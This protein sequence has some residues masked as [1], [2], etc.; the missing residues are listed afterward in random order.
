MSVRRRLMRE[1]E[2]EWIVWGLVIAML[3]VGLLLR[4]TIEGRTQSFSAIGV[5]LSYP[6]T[7]TNQAQTDQ[8]LYAADF[9]SSAQFPTAVMVRQVPMAEVGRNLASL[10][11][12]SLA[13]SARQ[14]Q[15]HL[16]YR[17]LSVKQVSVDGRE[18]AQVDYA[19]IPPAATGSSM[20]VVARAQDFLIRQGDTLT[21]ITL[22]ANANIAE[23][24]SGTWQAI[25][26][27]IRIK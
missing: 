19:Y 3:V 21:I 13:W 16:A 8:L 10:S 24:E 9:L 12:I 15:D 2:P 18:A 20:P 27:S 23:T 26:A 1:E 22:A 7:W 17:A 25:L 14:A 4:N 11:D 6:A 5:S